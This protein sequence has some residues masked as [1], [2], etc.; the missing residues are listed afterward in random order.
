[1]S[2]D[3]P[4]SPPASGPDDARDAAGSGSAWTPNVSGPSAQTGI[5]GMR[6]RVTGLLSGYTRTQK[7]VAAGAVAAVVIGVFLVTRLSGGVET[8]PLYTNLSAE[9]GATVTAA[10]EE[11]GVAYE[12]AANGTT[13]MVPA[14]QVDQLRL[15]LAGTALPSDS[16][17]G[18]GVLDDQG[19]TSSEFS[20]QVGYQRAMEG[21]LSKTIESIDVVDTAVVHLAIPDDSAFALDDQEA[22]ASVLVRTEAGQTL[23]D[24]QVR[25]VVNLVASSIQG[26]S[27]DAVTVADSDGNVLAAP[28]QQLAGAGGAGS[29]RRQTQQFEADLQSSLGS[30]LT[31]VVGNKGSHVT[32]AADL[33]YDQTNV[34]REAY[35]APAAGPDGRPLR[36]EE[37]TRTET[38]TGGAAQAGGVL[39]PDTPAA[40]TAGGDSDYSLEQD[41]VRFAVNRVVET[42]N[43]APGSIERLSVAVLVDEDKVTPTQLPQLTAA[44]TAAAG[45]DA[46]RGDVLEVTRTSFDTSADAAAEAELDAAEQEVGTTDDTVRNLAIAVVGLLLIVAALAAYLRGRRK[47][48][49]WELEAVAAQALPPGEPAMALTQEVELADVV[50]IDSIEPGA[51][52][53]VAPTQAVMA[54]PDPVE[55][56]VQQRD[57]RDAALGELIE[58]QPE[59]VAALLRSWLA[60][61][62]NG[63]R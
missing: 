14:D 18:Y 4:P 40:T 41:D 37:S 26:L 46:E 61:R 52:L 35:E 39:G 42:T 31:T 19:L 58:H 20:Q 7:L 36:T 30:L 60:D 34:A 13:I 27:P 62:R 2:L 51:T 44:L 55:L 47:A 6:D 1:V 33:D 17:V 59:E 23:G 28:G 25:A 48:H 63:P 29:S 10:L 22:S 43:E 57:E 5:A 12:L 9:D 8:A 16:K 49:Q 54:P 24:D 56:E 21:E 15:D 11:Q 50:E 45:I 3:A 38:Y 32:V 53:V